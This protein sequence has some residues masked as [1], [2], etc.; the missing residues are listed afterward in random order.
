MTQNQ[1]ENESKK[2]EKGVKQFANIYTAVTC[3][4]INGI[5]L[6]K[7]AILFKS[8]I[9]SVFNPSNCIRYYAQCSDAINEFRMM[10]IPKESITD[11]KTN[12]THK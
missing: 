6:L 5:S 9:F 8:S 7:I 3:E 12:A 10:T 11:T 2:I 1:T 4:L